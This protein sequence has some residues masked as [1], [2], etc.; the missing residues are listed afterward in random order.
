MDGF[1]ESDNVVVIAATNREF[2]LDD[3][4]IR[5]GR[6]DT[7]IKVKLPNEEDRIGIMKIHLRNVNKIESKIKHN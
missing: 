1:R 2:I 4:L 3:A 5:S 6:F 7:K